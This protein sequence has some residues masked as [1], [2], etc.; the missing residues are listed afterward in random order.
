MANQKNE[1]DPALELFLELIPLQE[2]AGDPI[3]KRSKIKII[4]KYLRE[5]YDLGVEEGW[6]AGRKDTEQAYASEE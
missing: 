6:D 2:A 4:D 1:D 5:A 3:L